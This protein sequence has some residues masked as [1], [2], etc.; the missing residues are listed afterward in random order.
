[1][2][3]KQEYFILEKSYEKMFCKGF[4]FHW[5][6]FNTR[7]GLLS[8]FVRKLDFFWSLPATRSIWVAV[9]FHFQENYQNKDFVAIVED[10]LCMKIR[11]LPKVTGAF[12]DTRSVLFITRIWS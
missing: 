1:M 12:I 6:L 4:N 11:H 5:F 9:T 10:D 8:W 2:Y 7:A 3:I